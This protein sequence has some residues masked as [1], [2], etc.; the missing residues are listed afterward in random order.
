MASLAQP[1]PPARLARHHELSGDLAAAAVAWGAAG[2]AALGVYSKHEALRFIARALAL[3]PEGAPERFELHELREGVLRVLGRRPEQRVELEAMR[4]HAERT[5][6]PRLLAIALSR[7]AR[8]DLDASRPVGVEAMLRRALEASIEAGDKSAEVEALRL[9][10][11]LRRDQ[12]D[13]H[14]AVEALDR[15]LARAGLDADQLGPRGQTLIQKAILLW[16]TG[17][18]SSALE[19]SA[20]AVA[21]FRRLGQKGLE[22]S[23]LNSLGVAL[24][25]SGAYEDA[26]AV[27]RASIHLDRQAGDRLHL[28]RK[29]SNLGQLYADLGDVPRALEFLKRAL[30]VFE[31]LDDLAGRAD[32][33]SA[34]AELLVEQVGDLD[35]AQQALD[36]SRTISVR[37]G[38][39]YD[40]AH[41][42]LVRAAL[43]EAQGDLEGA[44]RVAAEALAQSRA[45]AA[46]GYE[47]LAGAL[48]AKLLGRLGRSDAARD[49]AREV[50]T[51]VRAHGVVERAQRV[52]L[53][54]ATAWTL[55]EDHDGAA[56]ARTAARAVV[57]AHLAQIRAPELRERYLATPIVRAIR[58]ENPAPP[59]AP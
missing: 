39:P 26:V 37:L 6:E 15:A 1:V 14:G 11:Q 34:M 33:L 41:E 57:D 42:R 2:R 31:R 29:V 8:H 17:D 9:F 54:L 40:L 32:T 21:I 4:A 56:R 28:G 22:A 45:A 25:S 51:I 50:E 48:R 20:E 7:L 23:A 47:L 55:A 52:H 36:A 24:Y 19:S 35:A 43:L 58:A 16:R 30:D 27:V 10:G 53:E 46:V 12:G 13:V 3:L 49:A 59:E 18:L 44:E 5:R 38:D